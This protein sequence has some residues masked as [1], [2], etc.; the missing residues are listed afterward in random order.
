[1]PLAASPRRSLPRSSLAR[2]PLPFAGVVALAVSGA[3]SVPAA[4]ATLSAEARDTGLALLERL[5]PGEAGQP[6]PVLLNGQRLMFES[7]LTEQPVSAVLD[8]FERACR[9][10]PD[11]APLGPERWLQ[12]RHADVAGNVGQGACFA[13][14][15]ARSLTERLL[16][17][18]RD[19][20][21]SSL[22]RARYVLARRTP[23]GA[24][25]H[26]LEIWAPGSL[27]LRALVA[28]PG[29]PEASVDAHQ[30]PA[31]SGAEPVLDARLEGQPHA[32]RLFTS[33]EQPIALLGRYTR[34]IAARGF[35]V[36]PSVAGDSDAADDGTTLRRAFLSAELAAFVTASR[37]GG[38]T[39]LSLVEMARPRQ[40]SLGTEAP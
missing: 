21:L 5:A 35:E 3:A 24:G 26:V 11:A 37:V 16:D 40:A 27:S 19:G 30:L 15:D 36:V 7:R 39:L 14:A 33:A 17:F 12:A 31:P 1:M 6:Y 23:D 18:M 8:A 34:V 29:N 9:A 32:I 10:T 22:G 38:R 4:R 20:D 2:L 25:T 13:N 28:G